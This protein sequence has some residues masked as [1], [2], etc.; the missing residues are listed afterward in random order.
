MTSQY[1]I[2]GPSSVVVGR[3]RAA[4]NVYLVDY[5]PLPTDI[6]DFTWTRKESR[7]TENDRDEGQSQI[8]TATLSRYS[9]RLGCMHSHST[10]H[11]HTSRVQ[12]KGVGKDY[13]EKALF[14]YAAA[15]VIGLGATH[16]HVYSNLGAEAVSQLVCWTGRQAGRHGVISHMYNTHKFK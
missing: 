15:V 16:K 4:W 10:H 2:L 8:K 14:C 13:V 5:V 1:I 6:P 12:G 9:I 7:S 3:H 11:I